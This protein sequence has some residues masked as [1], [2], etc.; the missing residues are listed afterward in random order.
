MPIKLVIVI[1]RT[2][3]AIEKAV[4]QIVLSAVNLIAQVT[5]LLTKMAKNC[6]AQ[7]QQVSMPNIEFLMSA[8]FRM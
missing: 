1:R 6:M 5:I 7:L 2:T 3:S 8:I 4:M